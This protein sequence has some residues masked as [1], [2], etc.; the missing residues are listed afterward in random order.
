[1]VCCT[2]NL[3]LC[4]NLWSHSTFMNT[5]QG[6]GIYNGKQ[7]NPQQEY[8]SKQHPRIPNQELVRILGSTSA[9]NIPAGT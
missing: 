9:E 7:P 1:M 5:Y 8:W 4:F 6:K 3:V 2:M